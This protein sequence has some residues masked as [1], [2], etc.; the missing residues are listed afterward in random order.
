MGGI[1]V[2][3]PKTH[4][5]SFNSSV[6]LYC[7]AQIRLPHG[8]WPNI[9]VTVIQGYDAQ[10]T[11]FAPV[12][13]SDNDVPHSSIHTKPSSSSCSFQLR[14]YSRYHFGSQSGKNEEPGNRVLSNILYIQ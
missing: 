14:G 7:A 10:N 11:S 6:Q 2:I 9:K 5:G 8:Y 1:K 3:L 4:K 13:S 12:T